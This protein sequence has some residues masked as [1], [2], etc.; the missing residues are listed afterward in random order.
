M[1]NLAADLWFFSKVSISFCLKGTQTAEEYS[2][3]DLT[4]EK[5]AV[6]LSLGGHAFR[7]LQR[8]PWLEFALLVIL[9]MWP[10]HSRVSLRQTPRYGVDETFASVLPLRVYSSSKFLNLGLDTL[11]TEH[12]E[13]LKHI[14]HRSAQS[15]N[16]DR[17]LCKFSWSARYRRQSSAKR[18]TCEETVEGRSLVY[19]KKSSCRSEN[20]NL[21]HTGPHVSWFWSAAIDYYFLGS[22][23]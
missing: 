14:P 9:L 7:F 10:S 13:G 22:I 5:Y 4:R 12:F 20:S 23:F 11:R 3:D 21:G 17:S 19:V 18:R 8:K 16:A 6:S 15:R 1:T 2:K